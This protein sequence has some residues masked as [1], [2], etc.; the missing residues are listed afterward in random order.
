MK[1]A[2]WLNGEMDEKNNIIP[3]EGGE[4]GVLYKQSL[5]H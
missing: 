2:V 5:F 1:G 4:G 3:G